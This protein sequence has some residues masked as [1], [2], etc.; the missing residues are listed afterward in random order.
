ML[1]RII[2]V[3]MLKFVVQNLQLRT[4]LFQSRTINKNNLFPVIHISV[5]SCDNIHKQPFLS[6]FGSPHTP[7]I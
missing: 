7:L 5:T 3:Y 1:N 4:N 2:A 6:L